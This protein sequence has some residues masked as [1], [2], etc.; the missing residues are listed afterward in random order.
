MRCECCR[1]EYD[2]CV[3][4]NY[5]YSVCPEC[6]SRDVRYIENKRLCIKC[7]A[8]DNVKNYGRVWLCDDCEEDYW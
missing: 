5:G 1:H 8:I 3:F 4:D 6:A 7:G 2:E